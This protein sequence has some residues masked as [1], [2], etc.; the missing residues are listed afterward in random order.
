MDASFVTKPSP[1]VAASARPDPAPAR[2]TVATELGAGKAVAA[3]TEGQRAEAAASRS[4]SLIRTPVADPQ[5]REVIFRTLDVGIQ[6]GLTRMVRER[7]EQALRRRRAYDRTLARGTPARDV[8]E[9]TDFQ[10]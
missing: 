2:Q 3:I 7:R 1:N 10:A 5:S 6:P 8:R 9:R 4:G